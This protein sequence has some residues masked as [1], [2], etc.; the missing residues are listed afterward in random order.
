MI[1][2]TDIEKSILSHVF[3]SPN[4]TLTKLIGDGITSEFFSEGRHKTVFD[5]FTRYKRDGMEI[6]LISFCNHLENSGDLERIG[7]RAYITE[8]YTFSPTTANYTHH[9]ELLREA[10]AKRIAESMSSIDE[11]DIRAQS[12]EE[13]AKIYKDAS[14]RILEVTSVNSHSYDAK[15]ACVS[16]L[17]KLEESMRNKDVLYT[18]TGTQALDDIL[19]GIRKGEYWVIAGETSGGKSVLALQLMQAMLDGNKRVGLF[20]M[21]MEVETNISR[22]MSTLA[23]IDSTTLRNNTF[24]KHELIRIKKTTTDLASKNFVINDEPNITMERMDMIATQWN[25]AD[26]LDMIIADYIQLMRSSSQKQERTDERLSRIS[27]DLKGL[28]KKTQSCVV[29]LSQLNGDG[30]MSEAT[31]IINDA[32][33]V[34]R[35]EGDKGIY[36]MKNRNGERFMHIPLYLDGKFQRFTSQRSNNEQ[37]ASE[38]RASY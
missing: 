32:D 35:I 12:P 3:S 5:L 37:Q 31:R 14:Q 7:G 18:S 2:Y 34:L 10:H 13:L 33:V 24:S 22:M 16:Y 1:T 36:V 15:Q 6:E 9:V 26:G 28:A 11:N 38:E 20:S 21:E 19:G 27:G 17:A 30:R 25:D 8:L 29:A 23:N 4:K